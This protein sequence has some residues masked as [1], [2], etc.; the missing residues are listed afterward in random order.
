MIMEHQNSHCHESLRTTRS[1]TP[2]SSST[3]S[4][5]LLDTSSSNQFSEATS[6]VEEISNNTEEIEQGKDDQSLVGRLRKKCGKFVESRPVQTFIIISIILNSILMTIGTFDFFKNNPS[7]LAIFDNIE[8][9]FLCIYTVESFLQLM[10]RGTQIYKDHWSMFD[11]F[12][13]VLSWSFFFTSMTIQVA[14]ALRIIR[15]LLLVPRLKSLKTMATAM[16]CA[17][18]KLGSITAVLLLTFYMFAIIMTMLF[19][20]YELKTAYFTRLDTTLFT[21]FQI[22][23]MVDWT[24][25][26]RE[27]MV[28]VSWA[29]IL[30]ISFVVISGYIFLNLLVALVCEALTLA[31]EIN[32]E[33]EQEKEQENEQENEYHNDQQ[34]SISIR[35]V[36]DKQYLNHIYDTQK[37]ILEM[38]KSYDFVPR[39]FSS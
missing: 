15:V 4:Y 13:V 25:L 31:E 29:P 5:H 26:A 37:E 39:D 11:L 32:N 28:H 7:T 10:Y 35:T 16:T 38:L 34:S 9:V 33:K 19:K 17:L 6:S 3:G 12:L 1:L 20:D 8:T 36:T 30:I 23:T 22:M 21:L 2:P 24:P 18:P 14:R 27:L